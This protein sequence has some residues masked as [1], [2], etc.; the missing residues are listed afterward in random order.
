MVNEVLE[1][2]QSKIVWVVIIT[3]IITIMTILNLFEKLGISANDFQNIAITIMSIANTI[4]L[5]HD[6]S[7]KKRVN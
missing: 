6:P 1:R 4:G 2:L 5:L 7:D 3:N